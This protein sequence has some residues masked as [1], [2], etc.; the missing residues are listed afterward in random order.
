[1][2]ILPAEASD[3]NPLSLNIEFPDFRGEEDLVLLRALPGVLEAGT[4]EAGIQ[5]PDP[6]EARRAYY[7]AER[8]AAA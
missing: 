8:A 2:D 5:L 4:F 1:M 3:Q 6:R 7:A